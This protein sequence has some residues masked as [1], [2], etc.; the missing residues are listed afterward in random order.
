MK[1]LAFVAAGVLAYAAATAPVLAQPAGASAEVPQHKCGQV[2]PM[3]GERMM[4]DQTIRRR[5]EREVKTYGDCVKAYVAE[6]QASAQALNNQAKAHAEAA[7]AA[8][9]EYNAVLKK[10]N[11][12]QA[13]K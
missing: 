13:G 5:F 12:Q 7:N 8:V 3:P 2:P 1:T 9:I 11:E 6:R 4:E 10:L